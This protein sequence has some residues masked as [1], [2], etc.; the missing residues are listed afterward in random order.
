MINI[1][2]KKEIESK[3]TSKL[4]EIKGVL[5]TGIN[6]RYPELIG[7]L[8]GIALFYFYHSKYKDDQSSYDQGFKLISSAFESLNKGKKYHS[9]SN[10]AA[11]VGWLIEHLESNDYIN[12][13]TNDILIELNEF[14]HKAMQMEIQNKNLD[15]LHGAIGIG[16][17]YLQ[18]LN[19]RPE[20]AHTYMNLLMR[21]TPPANK[22][23]M[24][25]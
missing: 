20:V 14:A 19:K 7:G 4:D 25:G 12:S 23:S 2:V 21:L 10:G 15:Y 13:E 22:M 11:G 3:I 6:D 24:V 17:Y 1:P 5:D 8:S 18:R 9:F 16:L